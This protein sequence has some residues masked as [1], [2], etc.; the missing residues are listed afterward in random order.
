MLP[1]LTKARRRA[2]KLGMEQDGGVVTVRAA[3]RAGADPNTLSILAR[4]D[5]GWFRNLGYDGNDQ[6]YA[7]TDKGRRVFIDYCYA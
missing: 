3:I 7:L 5:V 4:D 6:R 1:T 2:L